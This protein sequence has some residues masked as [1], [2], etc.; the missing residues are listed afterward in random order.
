M[1]TTQTPLKD[2]SLVA[3][4]GL[5]CGTCK[6]LQSGKCSGCKENSKASWCKIRKCNMENGFAN[7]SECTITALEECKDL[8]NA[9][10][11]IYAYLFK[12]D[13]LA[14]LQYI[15]ENGAENYVEKMVDLGQMA[16]KRKQK[17]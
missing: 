17:I 7:C 1:T 13:R 5:Y 3:Y 2:P 10:G 4:C 8:N 15:K 12:T 9:I 16:L 6:R 14:S 11:K